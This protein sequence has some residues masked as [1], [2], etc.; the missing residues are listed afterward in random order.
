MA[1]EW[2]EQT[3][4]SSPCKF[5]GKAFSPCTAPALCPAGWQRSSLQGWA[6]GHRPR[7]AVPDGHR[8]AECS[9]SA[10]HLAG[11]DTATL[12]ASRQ[13]SCTDRTWLQLKALP[14]FTCC[15][16]LVTRQNIYVVCTYRMYR[17][18]LFGFLPFNKSQSFVVI[19]LFCYCCSQK[20]R[21]TNPESSPFQQSCP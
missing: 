11:R 16:I 7:A 17:L 19:V 9:P 10:G 20:H 14:G 3:I 12:G 2:F 4:P 6:M 13:L 18:E 1:T 15:F 21:K 8:A 5:L